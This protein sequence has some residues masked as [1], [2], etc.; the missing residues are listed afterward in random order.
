MMWRKTFVSLLASA[1]ASMPALAQSGTIAGSVT[2]ADGGRPISGA[3][4]SVLGTSRGGVT[5]EDGRYTIVVDPGTYRLRVRRIGF[6]PDSASGV[7]VSSG[8]V[9]TQDFRLTA[10]A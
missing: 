4:V 9:T 10:S 8:V 5:G 3:Q 1:I 6:A 2:T 7:V